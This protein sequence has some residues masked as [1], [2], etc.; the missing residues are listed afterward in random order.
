MSVFIVETYVVRP[1]KLDEF[2]PALNEFIKFKTLSGTKIMEALQTRIWWNN[3]RV[4]RNVGICKLSR[5]GK[6]K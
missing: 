1:E 6:D 4:H 5:H 2:T 3:S